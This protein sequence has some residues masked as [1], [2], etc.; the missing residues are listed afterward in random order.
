MPGEFWQLSTSV[1]VFSEC[2]LEGTGYLPAA[3]FWDP[4]QQTA[5]Q[6]HALQGGSEAKYPCGD[7]TLKTQYNMCPYVHSLT[8]M[9]SQTKEV[10]CLL[11]SL[12]S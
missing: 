12:A 8:Q 1:P 10:M 5:G 6:H 2:N 3:G 9:L 7:N 11:A 4:I